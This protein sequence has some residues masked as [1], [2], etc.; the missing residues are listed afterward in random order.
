M[1]AP[2]HWLIKSEPR[3]FAFDDLLNAPGRTS[4][5]DGVRNYQARNFI[6]DEMRPREFETVLAKDG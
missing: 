4:P 5:W 2:R 3:V 6:R 1:S